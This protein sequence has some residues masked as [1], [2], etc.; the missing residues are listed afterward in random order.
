MIDHYRMLIFSPLHWNIRYQHNY[1]LYH[2][3][4]VIDLLMNQGYSF[5]VHENE[6]KF[7]S[8]KMSSSI[9]IGSQPKPPLPQSLLQFSHPSVNSGI[10]HFHLDK[11]YQPFDI[12][13]DNHYYYMVK[14]VDL[15]AGCNFKFSLH[16]SPS[17]KQ[18]PCVLSFFHQKSNLL[19][20][21]HLY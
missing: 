10:V 2:R 21:I 9:N 8:P 11:S 15:F 3:N 4:M 5:F 6:N 13:L 19:F 1:H 17:Q 18:I 16:L 12:L 7:S 20:H 14:Y